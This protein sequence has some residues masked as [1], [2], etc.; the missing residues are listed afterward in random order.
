MRHG[1]RPYEVREP[2]SA[3][4][5]SGEICLRKRKE[6]GIQ[7]VACE[8]IASRP[9]I[10]GDARLI[11]PRKRYHVD[12]ASTEIDVSNFTRPVGNSGSP[13][14]L[15]GRGRNE[16]DSGQGLELL[17]RCSVVTV[18]VRVNDD[19]RHGLVVLPLGPLREQIYY[20]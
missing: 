17:V 4:T 14:N 7:A 20:H 1:V 8:E 13:L 5:E 18:C 3:R 12:N 11:V 15:C 16:L 9:V 6:S 10:E 19:Q 2:L